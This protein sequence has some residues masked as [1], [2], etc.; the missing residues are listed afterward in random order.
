VTWELAIALAL[1]GTAL[2]MRPWRML[3]GPLLTPVL[4]ALTFLPLGWLLPQWLPPGLPLR[5]SG[6]CLLVLALGWPLAMVS[7]SSVAAIVWVLGSETLLNVATHWIWLG[8]V[9]ATLAML[10][11]AGIRRWLP[12]HVFI[13]ILGRG[14]IGTGLCMFATGVLFEMAHHTLGNVVMADA[15]MARWFMA[16][17]DAFMTGMVVAI[18]VAFAP[19][20]L[21]TWSDQRYLKKPTELKR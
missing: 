4:A 2:S 18:G 20:R 16:W 14:F 11:G 3:N 10:L 21:A 19:Q 13:Y 6:A 5:W 17:S 8:V 7:L 12:D 15:V 9:P 1:L